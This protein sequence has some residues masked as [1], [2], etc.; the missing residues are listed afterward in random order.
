MIIDFRA[1]PVPNEFSE[2]IIVDRD[3]TLIVDQGY[4]PHLEKVEFISGTTEYILKQPSSTAI[5]MASNQSAI[6][7]G[8]RTIEEVLGFNR[9]ITHQLYSTHGAFPIIAICPHESSS[10]PLCH[11]RKPNSGMLRFYQS[12]FS[13]ISSSKFTF[14]GNSASD[15]EASKHINMRYIDVTALGS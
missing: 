13:G 10:P 4:A 14:L 5:V 11:C 12:Y 2:V 8:L 15:L 1:D 9:N 6:S 3:G 7:K